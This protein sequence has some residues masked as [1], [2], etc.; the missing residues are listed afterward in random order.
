MGNQNLAVLGGGHMGRALISGLLRR[1]S[2]PEDLTVAEVD[3]ATRAQLT[4]DFAVRAFERAH[5]AIGG[6]ALIVV[7]VKP[8]QVATLLSGIQ[9]ELAAQRALV[10]SV[11]AGIREAALR[12]WCGAGVTIVRA[13]PNCAALV[14]AGV[15]GLFAAQDVPQ[16]ARAAAER[17][18]AAVGETLWLRREDELDAVTALSGSG[19]AYLFALAEAMMQ[20]AVDLGLDQASARQLAIGTLYG[21]GMI[22]HESDGDLGALRAAVASKGGTT[23]AALRVFSAADLRG[24]TRAAMQAAAARSRELAGQFG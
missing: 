16:D 24:I 10:I 6:A 14:G 8:Q 23:E 22:A 15:S 18:L 5:E 4:R 11:V 7:A 3:A 17:V 12:E 21:A 13:M 19:P 20:A 2:R 1:G 9:A